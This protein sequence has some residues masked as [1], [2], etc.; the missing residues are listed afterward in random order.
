LDKADN[1]DSIIE[2]CNE[3]MKEMNVV[4]DIND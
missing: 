2:Y 3:K 1:V 4:R